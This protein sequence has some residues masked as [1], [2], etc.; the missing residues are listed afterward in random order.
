[1][2]AIQAAEFE[3]IRGPQAI[4]IDGIPNVA[5]CGGGLDAKARQLSRARGV[6]GRGKFPRGLPE[7]DSIPRIRGGGGTLQPRPDILVS[8]TGPL[9]EADGALAG[10]QDQEKGQPKQ[11]PAGTVALAPLPFGH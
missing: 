4:E 2:P 3:V 6:P 8:G 1:M 10:D 9:P 7:R 11:P 5:G